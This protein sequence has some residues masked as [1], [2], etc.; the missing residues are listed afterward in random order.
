MQWESPSFCPRD[1]DILDSP[2]WISGRLEA[3]P[4]L[5]LGV[6]LNVNITVYL[7]PQATRHHPEKCE[8]IDFFIAIYSPGY[9][10]HLTEWRIHKAASGRGGLFH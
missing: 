6:F 9:A 2:K 3:K 1:R 10:I 5:I 7:I 4:I 8:D